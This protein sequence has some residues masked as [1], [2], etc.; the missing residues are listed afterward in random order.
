MAEDDNCMSAAFAGDV[1]CSNG[2]LDMS[3]RSTWT[4]LNALI[5]AS[6]F[7]STE[8]KGGEVVEEAVD[9]SC[10]IGS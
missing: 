10:T 2:S 8:K 9:D 6:F 1:T 4:E 5:C 3:F 7:A